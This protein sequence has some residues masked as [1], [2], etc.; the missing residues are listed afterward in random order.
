MEEKM[1]NNEMEEQEVIPTEEETSYGIGAI[2][3]M[4]AVAVGGIFLAVKGVQAGYAY[5]K[6]HFFKKKDN[7]E[8]IEVE[9]VDSTEDET[10]E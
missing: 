4:S 2:A 8:P 6:K 5:A 3:L 7:C 10:E 9:V 1:I